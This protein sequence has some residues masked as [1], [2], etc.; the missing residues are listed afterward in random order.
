[1]SVAVTSLLRDKA[2]TIIASLSFYILQSLYISFINRNHV[3]LY[4]SVSSNFYVYFIVIYLLSFR[5]ENNS[6]QFVQLQL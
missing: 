1:M 2:A 5:S 4:F 3:F 6:D